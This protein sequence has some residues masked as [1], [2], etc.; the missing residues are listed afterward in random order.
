MLF[1]ILGLNNSNIPKWKNIKFK[2]LFRG[3]LK[4]A[5]ILQ[6]FFM[7]ISK[8]RKI[9]LKNWIFRNLIMKLYWVR[10]IEL[11]KDWISRIIEY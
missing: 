10:I 1:R 9:Y 4:L 6:I 3:I 2:S 5:K 8:L 7:T 11:W